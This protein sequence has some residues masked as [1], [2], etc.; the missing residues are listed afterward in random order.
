MK[1][2]RTIDL[3]DGE[4]AVLEHRLDAGLAR[5][6]RVPAGDRLA[7]DED[8]AAG[9]LDH[10]GEDL[11][12]RRLAGAIVADQADDLAAVDVQV[13]AAERIDAAVG[14]RDVAQF[15][16][17]LAHAHPPRLRMRPARSCAGRPQRLQI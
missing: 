1:I 9:R 5:A 16:E 8:L 2:L 17:A 6:R 13:D 14:L 12:Q 3:L 11:D 7:A 10:A 15:D 4:R